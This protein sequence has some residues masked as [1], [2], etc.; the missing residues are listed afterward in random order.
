MSKTIAG[1]IGLVIFTGLIAGIFSG[2]SMKSGEDLDPESLLIKVL[3]IF[4][5]S[6][7]G[8]D[9][10]YNTCKSGFI[11]LTIFAFIAGILEVLALIAPL[12]NIW[13]GLG[14]YVFGWIIGLILVLVN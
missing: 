2:A 7:K 9:A 6:V 10:A 14:L 3:G 4:C 13:I 8:V 11:M 5:D 1:L 12:G